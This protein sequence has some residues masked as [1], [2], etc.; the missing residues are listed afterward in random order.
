MNSKMRNDSLGYMT[1]IHL[2]RIGSIWKK[3]LFLYMKQYG[4]KTSVFRSYQKMFNERYINEFGPV[5]FKT[6]DR[7]LL[8]KKLDEINRSDYTVVSISKKGILYLKEHN[9]ALVNSGELDSRFRTTDIKKYLRELHKSRVMNLFSCTGAFVFKSEKPSLMNLYEFLNL[10]PLSSQEGYLDITPGELKELLDSSS[11]FYTLDEF[12]EFDDS[13][14]M[15]SSDR[16]RSSKCMGISISKKGA[17]MVYLSSPGDNKFIKFSNLQA[18][19]NIQDKIENYLGELGF[20]DSHISLPKLKRKDKK[21]TEKIDFTPVG[22]AVDA[23]VITDGPSLIYGMATGRKS[24]LFK[25]GNIKDFDSFYT[26]KDMLMYGSVAFKN[27]FALPCSNLGVLNLYYLLNHSGKEYHLDA[28]NYIAEREDLFTLTD[29]IGDNYSWGVM[30]ENNYL[31]VVADR[32]IYMPVFEINLMFSLSLR[33][34]EGDT[35]KYETYGII[36]RPEMVDTLAHAIRKPCVYYDL[37]TGDRIYKQEASGELKDVNVYDIY[38][39]KITGEDRKFNI[40]KAPKRIKKPVRN[41]YIN[42]ETQER[43]DLYKKAA[44]LSGKSFSKLAMESL[45][46]VC[47]EVIKKHKEEVRGSLANMRERLGK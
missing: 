46:L 27:I 37:N 3:D 13:F 44:K 1:L 28:K 32:V 39:Y 15:G 26:P 11:I 42:C 8:H 43:I 41:L 20:K 7:E 22:T 9:E 21:G 17:Y 6:K 4:C 35:E 10:E 2:Y 12:R 38:G 24:G 31:G 40:H 5:D 23:I 16:Y 19:N 36:T 29:R 30:K 18:E 33:T 34:I 25:S 45:D 14:V 47:E